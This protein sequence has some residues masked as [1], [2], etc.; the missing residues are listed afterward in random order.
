M[1]TH[2][3]ETV[4]ARVVAIDTPPREREL[5]AVEVLTYLAKHGELTHM[6]DERIARAEICRAVLNAAL[7]SFQSLLNRMPR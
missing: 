5:S 7:D 6:P 1:P 4:Y 3:I 2:N